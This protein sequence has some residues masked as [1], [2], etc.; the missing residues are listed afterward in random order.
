MKST[1]QTFL[2][3]ILILLFVV[4]VTAQIPVD[5]ING[6]YLLK[7]NW[8][9]DDFYPNNYIPG[10]NTAGCHSV[11]FAQILYFH[12][13]KPIG[14]VN[15]TSSKGYSINENFQDYYPKWELMKNT[16]L[17]TY[18]SLS[19]YEVQKYLYCVAA[20][21][22]KDFG[23]GSYMKKFHKKQLQQHFNCKVKEYLRF[24]GFFTSNRKIKKI[25]V[26]EIEAERPVY[27]HYTNLNGGGHSIV[28]DGYQIIDGK[29]FVHFNFGWGG[30]SNGW[31][32]PLTPI[33]NPDDTKLRII[34]TIRPK[35]N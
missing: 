3:I 6:D 26:K 19:I 14:E 33:A 35:N 16:E 2:C 22:Q 7:T 11:A 12:K 29:L 18:N 31:Y 15:Y 17:K 1:N 27:F 5:S 10:N 30:R 28:A 23:T 34:T 9:G 8:A 4:E 25:L 21:V 13:I 32:D 20:T 24:K